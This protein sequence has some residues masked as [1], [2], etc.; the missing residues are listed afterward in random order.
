MKK[1][2][3][4]LINTTWMKELLVCMLIGVCMVVF[5]TYNNQTCANFAGGVIIGSSL[6]YMLIEIKE[7]LI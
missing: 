7:A 5:G 3:K 1:F 6:C 2:D 4:D